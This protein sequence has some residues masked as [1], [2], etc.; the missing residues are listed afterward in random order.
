MSPSGVGLR[1]PAI[2]PKKGWGKSGGMVRRMGGGRL[3]V[4][5]RAWR[6]V[7]WHGGE[8]A[9]GLLDEASGDWGTR[10]NSGEPSSAQDGKEENY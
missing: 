10:V 2:S 7:A 9:C 1:V 3:A 5:G 4:A 8:D 6:G